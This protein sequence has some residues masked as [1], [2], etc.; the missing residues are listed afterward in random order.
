MRAVWAETGGG[1]EVLRIVE[2]ALPEPQANQIRI[3]VAAAGINNADIVQRKSGIAPAGAPPGLGLE[4]SGTV[5]AVGEDVADWS[6]G[7]RVCA[8]L[9]GGGYGD[10]ALADAR[11]VLP[12]PDDITHCEAAGLPEALLTVWQNLVVSGNCQ[13]GDTVLVHGG[14][15]GIGSMAVQV[16]KMLGARVA[17]TAGSPER[18]N[19]LTELGAD[20]AINHNEED[21]V[22]IV[23]EMGGADVILDIVGGPYL[24]RNLAAAREG[25]RIV[26]IAFLEGGETT[27]DLALLQH[28]RLALTG[29]KLRPRSAAHKGELTDA[30]RRFVWPTVARRGITAVIDRIF[31]LAEVADAHR[32][33]EARR[34]FGKVILDL[35]N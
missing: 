22:T 24:N 2:R 11:S 5:D 19:R 31:P 20:R 26:Q 3:R 27:I 14:G 12:V 15:S 25:A 33:F 16:A 6:V 9:D 29:S 28:K 21:F 4:V 34:H 10:F 7:Q 8:L 13:P 23:S 32:Y 18:C 17:T 35:Q 1:A 30:I